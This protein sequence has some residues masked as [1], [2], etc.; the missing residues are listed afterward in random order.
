MQSGRAQTAWLQAVSFPAALNIGC[1]NNYT[2]TKMCS[3]AIQPHY[4]II[5]IIVIILL[6]LLSLLLNEWRV[7]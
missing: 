2:T 5:I 4:F 1:R 3:D 6:L 7:V